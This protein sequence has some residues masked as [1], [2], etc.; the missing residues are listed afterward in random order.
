MWDGAAGVRA[1]PGLRP[2]IPAAACP[3]VRG[4]GDPVARL[5]WLGG[6]GQ[7]LIDLQ[8]SARKLSAAVAAAPSGPPGLT[9]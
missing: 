3:H 8:C 6:R 4:C 1:T 2:A 9:S 5:R 7:E